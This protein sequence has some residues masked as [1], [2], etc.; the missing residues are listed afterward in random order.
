[1]SERPI[2]KRIYRGKK[3]IAIFAVALCAPRRNLQKISEPVRNLS[4]RTI[5]EAEKVNVAFKFDRL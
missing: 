4:Q 5:A 1:M 3:G 2:I